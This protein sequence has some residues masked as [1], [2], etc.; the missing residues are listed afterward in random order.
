MEAAGPWP[1]P[2]RLRTESTSSV[3]AYGPTYCCLLSTSS[4]ATWEEHALEAVLSACTIMPIY[5][6]AFQKKLA[7]PMSLK[8]RPTFRALTFKDA[9]NAIKL[10]AGPL[11]D[12]L[13]GE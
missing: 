13:S 11:Q 12:I 10:D 3:I 8:T 6:Q 4:I 5:P 7:N 9:K 1:P 2:V